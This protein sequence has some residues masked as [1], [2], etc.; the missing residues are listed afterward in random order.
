MS[1]ITLL[2][3]CALACGLN[4]GCASLDGNCVADAYLAGQRDGRLG[5][6]PQDG[7]YAARCKAPFDRARYLDGWKAGTG[8]R[9]APSV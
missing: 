1:R 7:R 2:A 5:A 6:A 9:P 3:A 4:A 8:Q